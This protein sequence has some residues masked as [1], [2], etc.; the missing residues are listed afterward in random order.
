M[1]QDQGSGQQALR[2]SR[3]QAKRG[4]KKPHE[5]SLCEGHGG[6]YQMLF[7]RT[8]RAGDG[9]ETDRS[10]ELWASDDIEQA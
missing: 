3:G 10:N 4:L 6:A 8:W 1:L 2:L 5:I 9:G 7:P